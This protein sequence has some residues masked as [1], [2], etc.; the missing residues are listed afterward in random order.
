MD[1]AAVDRATADG[2]AGG[3]AAAEGMA[4]DRTAADGTVA[5][6]AAA[7]GAGADSFVTDRSAGRARR[8]AGVDAGTRARAHVTFAGATARRPIPPSPVRAPCGAG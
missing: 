4:A 1:G 6:R 5:G 8:T 2:V 3:R 7:D